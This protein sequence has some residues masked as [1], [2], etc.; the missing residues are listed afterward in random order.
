[1]WNDRP[2]SPSSMSARPAPSLRQPD[3]PNPPPNAL[4]A[5]RSYDRARRQ[6]LVR[7]ITIGIGAISA[8]LL[9][10]AFLPVLD[11]VSVVAISAVL[12]GS[13]VGYLINRAD[14]VT[15]AGYIVLAS[16]TA[17]IAWIIAARGIQQGITPT[18]LRL[19]D[20]F[21]L[22][23]I[24]S[25]VLSS[26]RTPIVFGVLIC[27]FTIASL[28]LL[29]R[30]VQ[31][32]LYW[33]GRDPQTLGS[34]YDVVAIP[35]VIQAL[36][37]V[38]AWLGSDSVRR[39]LLSATRADELALAND[40]VLRQTREMELHQRQLQDSIAHLQLVHN[41]FA[42]GNFDARAQ[43]PGDELQPLAISVNR[44]LAQMQR[45]LREQD[46]RARI[47]YVARELTA[48]LRRYRAGYGYQPPQY[49]GTI[50]D[51]VLL[52]LVS[53]FQRGTSPTPPGQAP[54]SRSAPPASGR[55]PD[56]SGPI[57]PPDRS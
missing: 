10:S 15:L 2:G 28:L 13:V 26:R 45:L 52:E 44:F 53:V 30:A 43:L 39:S 14:H 27:G 40:L 11:L 16:G 25:G 24:I 56:I 49:T 5:V 32:Q 3:R 50:F 55:W 54:D 57:P 48:A 38:V 47:E 22:P 41:A 8:I 12:L 36:A 31:L 46:Q 6:R 42:S 20:F 18:D 29:P 35:V 1:M 7:L 17:G 37:A 19:Y 33:D 23:I 4:D 21:V 34:A 9:P 51:E